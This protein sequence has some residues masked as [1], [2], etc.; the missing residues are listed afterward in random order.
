MCECKYGNQLVAKGKVLLNGST[1]SCGCLRSN[2]MTALNKKRASRRD[3][4]ANFRHPEYSRWEGIK[5]RCYIPTAHR[6][7][8]WGG[9]C[10]RMS[11]EWFEDFKCFAEYIENTLGEC[12]E[13]YTLDRIN[14]EGH[15]EAGNVRWASNPIQRMNTRKHYK[16]LNSDSV[17]QY[18]LHIQH[19]FQATQ[20]R[21]AR[22]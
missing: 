17:K 18:P 8:D 16:L 19:W 22:Y 4:N 20:V 21:R 12:P 3:A 11:K 1:R 5:A 6:Y 15:Y 9:R 2:N 13:G 10:I 14:N 7:S